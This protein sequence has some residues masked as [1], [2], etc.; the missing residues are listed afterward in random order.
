M[1]PRLFA[2]EIIVRRIEASLL[3]SCFNEAA[4]FRRGNLSGGGPHE[5]TVRP[6]SMRPRLFAAEISCVQACSRH[7]ARRFNEAAAFRRG[8]RNVQLDPVGRTALLQ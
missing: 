8:N 6:A 5:V 7:T 3:S 2:A 1:R 4:A